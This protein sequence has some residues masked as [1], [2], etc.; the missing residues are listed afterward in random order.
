M[1]IKPVFKRMYI[2]LAAMKASFRG[3]CRPVVGVDGCHLKGCFP[4]ILLV[5][6]AKDGNNTIYPIAWAVV[7]T[8]NKE[9]WAWFFDLL[10]N[11][12]EFYDGEGLTIMSDR[13]KVYANLHIL[14]FMMVKDFDFMMLTFIYCFCRDFWMQ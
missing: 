3:G 6:V 12:L 1:T 8:E 11:D 7:E 5:A 10:L 9:S 13:Q 2:C 4:G 14:L